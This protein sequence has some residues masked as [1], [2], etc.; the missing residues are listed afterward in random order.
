MAELN[1]AL[2]LFPSGLP[3]FSI[4]GGTSHDLSKYTTCAHFRAGKHFDLDVWCGT[5]ACVKRNAKSN[6]QRLNSARTT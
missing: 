6:E 5:R 4:T 1:G 2:P 3:Q